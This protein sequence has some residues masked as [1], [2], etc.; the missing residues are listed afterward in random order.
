MLGNAL[1][2]GNVWVEFVWAGYGMRVRDG[3]RAKEGDQ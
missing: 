1:G 2:K 3:F